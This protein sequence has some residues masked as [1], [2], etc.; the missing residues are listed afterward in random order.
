MM[1]NSWR[2]LLRS[3]F[4]LIVACLGLMVGAQNARQLAYATPNSIELYDISANATETLV[5]DAGS[6]WE[7]LWSPD[8][9]RL[10]FTADRGGERRL[11]LLS[12]DTKDVIQLTKDVERLIGWMPDSERLLFTRAVVPTQSDIY[13]VGVDTQV[14]RLLVEDV[15]SEGYPG[16]F[17][18]P[19]GEQLVFY[20][21]IGRLS[22]DTDLIR[23]PN[24]LT[25]SP[26]DP[27]DTALFLLEFTST[28]G[29]LDSITWTQDS[30]H[31]AFLGNYNA[32]WRAHVAP[33]GGDPQIISGDFQLQKPIA[34]AWHPE[35]TRLAFIDS[36]SNSLSECLVSV[37]PSG[38]Q[39]QEL[40]CLEN[41]RFGPH[42]AWSPD[43]KILLYSSTSRIGPFVMAVHM[44][45]VQR[46]IDIPLRLHPDARAFAW[47]PQ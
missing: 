42:L 41:G 2:A 34:P 14:E 11:Y 31:I 35:G 36:R 40:V 12:M 23:S 10:V 19:D 4:V 47:R 37:S 1:K 13:V 16:P 29:R 5:D 8:G 33:I 38:A 46:R 44:M 17:L 7:L 22:I 27:E 28:F 21:E 24:L 3:V 26:A 9:E 45:D 30:E 18:R 20:S 6:I 43:G 32:G 39:R 25:V 15:L